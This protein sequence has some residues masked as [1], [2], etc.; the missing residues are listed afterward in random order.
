MAET[1]KREKPKFVVRAKLP[2]ND[3]V[4]MAWLQAKVGEANVAG[5]KWKRLTVHPE[6]KSRFILEGWEERPEDEGEPQWTEE[7]R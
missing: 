2:D 4:R 5:C 6:D 1:A 3:A 7:G